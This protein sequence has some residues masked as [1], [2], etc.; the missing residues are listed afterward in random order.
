MGGS[1]GLPPSGEGMALAS[2]QPNSTT[3]VMTSETT[4]P[5]LDPQF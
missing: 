5:N 1:W 3:G 4:P 2:A